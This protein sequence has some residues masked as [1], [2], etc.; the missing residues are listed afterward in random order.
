M[1]KTF[2]AFSIGKRNRM[3]VAGAVLF[4]GD[5]KTAINKISFLNKLKNNRKPICKHAK[6]DST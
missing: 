5:K 2:K 3:P 6:D 4:N 1:S